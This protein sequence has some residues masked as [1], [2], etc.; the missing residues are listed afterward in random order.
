MGLGREIS[1]INKRQYEQKE[2]GFYAAG[3][4]STFGS[5]MQALTGIVPLGGAQ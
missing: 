4:L 5:L 2:T 3:L 1:K